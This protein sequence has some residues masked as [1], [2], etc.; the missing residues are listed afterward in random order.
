L[1]GTQEFKKATYAGNTFATQQYA[2]KRMRNDSNITIDYNERVGRNNSKLAGAFGTITRIFEH[3]MYPGGPTRLVLDC[4]WFDILGVV[5]ISK[6]IVVERNPDNSFNQNARF[7][8][9]ITAYQRPVAVWPSDPLGTRGEPHTSQFEI[10]DPN[11][12]ARDPQIRLDLPVLCAC[13]TAKK[14]NNGDCDCSCHV[15]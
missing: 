1:L 8:F 5:E 11:D 10:I 15:R 6:T 2:A 14:T 7:T 13:A 9:L 4:A 3:S 12:T